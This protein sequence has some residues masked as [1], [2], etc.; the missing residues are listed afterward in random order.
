MGKRGRDGIWP[1]PTGREDITAVEVLLRSKVSKL[2]IKLL[3]LG[4]TS[5]RKIIRQTPVTPGFE[6]RWDLHPEVCRKL[7]LKRAHAKTLL[8]QVPEAAV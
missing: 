8:P 6:N 3:S 4:G 1:G 7:K 5:T 2:H